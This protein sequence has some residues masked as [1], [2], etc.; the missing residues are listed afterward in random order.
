MM[1]SIWLRVAILLPELLVAVFCDITQ[2]YLRF[3]VYV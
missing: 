3:T 1:K 2:Q